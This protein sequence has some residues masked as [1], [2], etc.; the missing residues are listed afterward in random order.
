MEAKAR[1]A[2]ELVQAIREAVD[3]VTAKILKLADKTTE[4]DKEL[5][6]LEERLAE[7]LRQLDTI[8]EIAE[9]AAAFVNK[10]ARLTK[11]LRLPFRDAAG[12]SADAEQRAETLS[13]V[14]EKLKTLRENLAK[15]RENKQT[16]Q[17]FAETLVRVAR[18]VDDELKSLDSKWHEVRHSALAWRTE[19]AELRPMVSGWT[20]WAAVIGSA[21]LAWIGLG[22]WAL[23]R[24][25]WRSERV[26]E[27]QNR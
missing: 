17:E 21:I 14:A 4:D 13:N 12:P 3:P 11:S 9:T 26:D 7:R 25:G 10:T 23:A 27:K 24:W 18:E 22:Q 15:V 5:K 20:N 19:V 16:Q 1:R 6:R 2:N 8:T